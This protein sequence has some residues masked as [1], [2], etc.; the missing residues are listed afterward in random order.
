MLI[1][2]TPQTIERIDEM[3]RDGWQVWAITVSRPMRVR[4]VDGDRLAVESSWD[5]EC[6]WMLFDTPQVTYHATKWEPDPIDLPV[7]AVRGAMRGLSWLIN[8]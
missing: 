8:D 4:L 5:D 3:L 2:E 1:Q 6:F 7:W